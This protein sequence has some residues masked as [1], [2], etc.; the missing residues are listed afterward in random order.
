MATFSGDPRI[1][2]QIIRD[3]KVLEDAIKEKIN[4]SVRKALAKLTPEKLEELRK[5]YG[6]IP[7]S[8]LIMRLSSVV[9]LGLGA[10]RK[11]GDIVDAKL[12]EWSD[13]AKVLEKLVAFKIDG[14]SIDEYVGNEV[15]EILSSDPILANAAKKL[16]FSVLQGVTEMSEM[17]RMVFMRRVRGLLLNMASTARLL[18]SK[19][20]RTPK[21]IQQAFSVLFQSILGID[22]GEIEGDKIIPALAKMITDNPEG[23]KRLEKQLELARVHFEKA[24]SDMS[25]EALLELASGIEKTLN[26][27]VGKGIT[28]DRVMKLVALPGLL[29]TVLAIP[30][31]KNTIFNLLKEAMKSKSLSKSEIEA[32]VDDVQVRVQ[33]GLITASEKVSRKITQL[34]PRSRALLRDTA[35]T[36]TREFADSS[37]YHKQ[38]VARAGNKLVHEATNVIAQARELEAIQLDELGS[39]ML[40]RGGQF[41]EEAQAVDPNPDSM[42]NKI[43]RGIRFAVRV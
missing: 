30:E 16:L 1:D 17:K 37:A 32:Q 3:A 13:E 28:I 15:R 6:S 40:Y 22:L 9:I 8:Q 24:L 35:T 5:T 7:E 23:Q 4:E 14:L 26:F 11:V 38:A 2:L 41:I 36:L 25:K 27:S 43:E 10:E 39:A 19:D 31:V 12:T 21:D 42:G 20:E 34:S 33:S 29:P 18:A